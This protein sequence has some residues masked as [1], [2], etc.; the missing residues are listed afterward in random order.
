[1]SFLGEDER[2]RVVWV[3]LAGGKG[4][5]LGGKIPKQ[6]WRLG[7]RPLL[8]YAIETFLSLY[9]DNPVVVV[10]PLSHFQRGQRI[11]F[12]AFPQARLYLTVGGDTRSASTEAAL[13]LLKELELLTPEWV[14]AFH[15]AA[16]PFVSKELINRL[17][18]EARERGAAVCGLPV[19]FSVRW[20]EGENSRAI[21][22]ERIWE[23]QTPQAFRGDILHSAWKKLPPT[24]D[25]AFTDEGSWIE[26]VGFPVRLV[27]GEPH[28]LKI[29]HPI[30]WELARLWLRRRSR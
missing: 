23:V 13:G 18:H 2:C 27:A 8:L 3:Q 28:N 7:K 21:N 4:L 26:A 16:R 6:F 10:L 9:P 17:Y 25:P 30:D 1:M 29:T 11:L 22:R 20:V 19:S 24:A 12:E 15:D 14:I 5:R